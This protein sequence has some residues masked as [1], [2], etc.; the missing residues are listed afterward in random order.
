MYKYHKLDTTKSFH[1][2]KEHSRNHSMYKIQKHKICYMYI[3]LV[4]LIRD[5]FQSD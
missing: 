5:K 3:Y 1:Q 2:A 4:I